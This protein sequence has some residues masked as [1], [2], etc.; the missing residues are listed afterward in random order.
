ML[1]IPTTLTVSGTATPCDVRAEIAPNATV[2]KISVDSSL[3]A[4]FAR[5]NDHKP[6]ITIRGIDPGWA[7]PPEDL[8]CTHAN[9]NLFLRRR[10]ETT[11]VDLE[12]D[13]TSKH[14]KFTALGRAFKTQLVGGSSGT[15]SETVL[16]IYPDYDNA[17]NMVP[18]V[19]TTAQQIV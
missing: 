1:S 13:N 4:H 11:G 6:V 5:V 12:P 19:A 2:E 16:V 7:V 8:L 10:G 18:I 15:P 17:T 14:L 3:A 9:T